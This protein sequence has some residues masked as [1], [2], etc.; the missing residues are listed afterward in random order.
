MHEKLS[1]LTGVKYFQ[2][3]QLDESWL[4]EERSTL[5]GVKYFPLDEILLGQ[6]QIPMVLTLYVYHL[7]DQT[8]IYKPI[9]LHM[10]NRHIDYE[11]VL[12][13]VAFLYG[14]FWDKRPNNVIDSTENFTIVC[15]KR[16]I[17]TLSIA[18]A[19]LRNF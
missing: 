2:Y 18:K 14:C 9:G 11:N 10:S 5:T 6:H 8:F 3:F 19:L 16:Q 17:Q 15:H 1:T 7:I 12:Y 4:H 13:K